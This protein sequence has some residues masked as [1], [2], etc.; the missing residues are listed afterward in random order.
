[1]TV[2]TAGGHE[3]V[4]EVFKKQ[5]VY[6]PNKRESMKCHDITLISVLNSVLVNQE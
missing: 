5:S 2:T 4:L 3:V 6:W 1:M